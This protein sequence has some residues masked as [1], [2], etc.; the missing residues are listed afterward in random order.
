MSVDGVVRIKSSVSNK[1]DLV[2]IV[3]NVLLAV[4]WEVKGVR[5]EAVM[6]LM[7]QLGFVE[8]LF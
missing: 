1:E 4:W 8:L 6:I 3:V 7:N 2:R 5:S